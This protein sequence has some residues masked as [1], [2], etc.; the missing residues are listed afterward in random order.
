MFMKGVLFISIFFIS[1]STF[2]QFDFSTREKD[3]AELLD[4]MRKCQ[5]PSKRDSLNLDFYRLLLTTAAEPS[6]FEQKFTQLKTCGIITSPDNEV[7]IFNW[8]IEQVDN[9]QKYYGFIV[10]KNL[11]NKSNDIFELNENPIQ[12]AKPEAIIEVNDWYGCLY[13]QIIPF[14]KSN[15]KKYILLGW[16]GGSSFSNTKL[17]DVLS[18]TGNSAK[19]GGNVFKIGNQ[20]ANRIFFEHSEQSVMSLRYEA[21]RKRIIF[22]HLSPE[23]PSLVGI[24]EYYVP[25][26]SYDA[27]VYEKNKWVLKEDVIAVNK[28]T[29][30]VQ[31]FS[32]DSK[33]DEYVVSE[34][35]TSEWVDP[36]GTGPAGTGVHTAAL[37]EEDKTIDNEKKK[38]LTKAEKKK[39]TAL[40]KYE[41]KK[42]H[43]E[44]KKKN[45][46]IRN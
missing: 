32:Y 30:D 37:P 10:R 34:T 44:D 14:E 2:A 20:T 19:L 25:D 13:Y 23:T 22:D 8:N 35:K 27:L 26:M 39:L 28:E 40:E 6:I 17:V 42:R 21:E 31:K 43:R 33:T 11:R 46:S 7:V 4:S 38:K 24:Y 45:N 12:M 9:S 15:Q 5:D 36:S 41:L 3:L 1:C 16:D 29:P 18:F